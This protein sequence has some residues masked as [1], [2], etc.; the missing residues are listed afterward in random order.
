M[1]E[2]LYFALDISDKYA[3]IDGSIDAN[4]PKECNLN[5]DVL[6]KEL[7]YLKCKRMLL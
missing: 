4:R 1:E 5:T 7:L 6:F 3:N 2:I